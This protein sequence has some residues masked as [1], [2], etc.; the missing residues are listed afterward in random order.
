LDE[1]AAGFRPHVFHTHDATTL[2]LQLVRLNHGPELPRVATVHHVPRFATLYLTLNGEPP[3][4]VE[5]LVWAYSKWL[6]NRFDH[7]VFPT[8]A[9]RERFLQKGLQAPSTVISNGVDMRRYRPLN[10]HQEDVDV[11]YGLP[12]GPRILFVGRLA[13]DKEIDVLIRAMRPLGRRLAAHLLLVGKG[14]DR[15]RL[16]ALVDELGLRHCIHFLGFVPEVDLPA[17]YRAVDLFAIASACEVQSLPTLQAVATGLPVVAADAVALPELVED[18]IN[19]F[20]FPPGDPQ[21]LAEAIACILADRSLV[22]QMGRA[23]LAM[24]QAHGEERTYEAY[25]NLYC[26]VASRPF[27]SPPRTSPSPRFTVR[28]RQRQPMSPPRL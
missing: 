5:S 19:G 15:P 3:E 21:A 12:P 8:G 26:E 2:G 10:G 28:R 22:A 7:I 24:A 6:L 27:R 13:Q 20:L 11:R 18:D 25:E 23:S 16:E 1:L 9:H 4:A 17:L 14:D